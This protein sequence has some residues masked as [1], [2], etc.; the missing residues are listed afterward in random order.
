VNKFFILTIMFCTVQICM[1]QT[2]VVRKNKITALVSEKYNTIIAADRQIKQGPYQ[3]MYNKKVVIA[4]GKYADDKR[5]GLWRFFDENQKVSQV[6]DY[7][8]GKLMFEAPEDSTS[9]F[10]YEIDANIT[11][12]TVATKPIRQGGRYFGYL[13]YLR[14]F[15]FPLDLQGYDPESIHI[16]LELFISPMGRVAEFKIHVIAPS[17]NRAL[18][19]DPDKLNP[20]DRVFTPATLNSQPIS[21]RILI[22]CYVTNSGDLDMDTGH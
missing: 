19:V 3:A 17:Y 11:D 21:S 4:Q 13:P 20:E 14:F 22:G 7:D 18:S 5:V 8:L 15:K 16:V 9:N 1:A 2:L 10:R 12:S 6:Y